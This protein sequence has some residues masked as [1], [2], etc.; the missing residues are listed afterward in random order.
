M[1]SVQK[2]LLT[3]ILFDYEIKLIEQLNQNHFHHVLLHFFS[4]LTTVTGI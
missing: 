1:L 2:S 3:V 4:L